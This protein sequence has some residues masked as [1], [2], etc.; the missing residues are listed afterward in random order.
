MPALKNRARRNGW[1]LA[2][3]A[4]GVTVLLGIGIGWGLYGNTTSPLD[5]TADPGAKSDGIAAVVL[6]PPKQLQSLGGLTGLMEQARKRFGDTIG[7][8][9]VIYPDVRIAGPPGPQRRPPGPELHLPRRLG[10][11]VQQLAR[12]ASTAPSLTSASST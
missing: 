6:T 3:A 4:F 5:F 8:R 9:L 10:R 2:A 1:G 7:Y 12:A 11:S